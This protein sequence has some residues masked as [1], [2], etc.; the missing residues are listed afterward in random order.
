MALFTRAKRGKQPKCPSVDKWISKMW[1][2]HAI[3]CYSALKRNEILTHV[4][5]WINPEDVTQ[6][7]ISQT[8]KGKC[9]MS[10]PILGT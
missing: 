8:Q 3:E 5:A 6:N 1:Y 10:L 4:T 9:P 7:E 2:R